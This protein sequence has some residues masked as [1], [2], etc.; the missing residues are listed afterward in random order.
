MSWS[1]G[2]MTRHK[3]LLAP[4]LARP[5]AAAAAAANA[6]DDVELGGNGGPQ[7]SPA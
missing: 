1:Q 5:A 6:D 4:S 2:E 3:A 7:L